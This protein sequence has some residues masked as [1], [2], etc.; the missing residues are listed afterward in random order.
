MMV[1]V[2]IGRLTVEA[3]SRA[4]ALRIGDALRSRLTELAAAGFLPKASRIERLD[5]G[6][7]PPGAGPEQIGRHAAERI[8]QNL[9]GAR[10][11]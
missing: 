4:E 6:K 3:A 2:H 7:V 9:K 5:A 11:V 1:N 8:F 10:H